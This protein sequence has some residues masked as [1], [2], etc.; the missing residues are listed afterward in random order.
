MQASSQRLLYD[1]SVAIRAGV[2]VV[3]GAGRPC[4]GMGVEASVHY[5][6]AATQH[7]CVGDGD[8]SDD[9]ESACDTSSEVGFPSAVDMQRNDND[10]T[11][12]SIKH[13]YEEHECG[14]EDSDVFDGKL[15]VGDGC[16]VDGNNFHEGNEHG[17]EQSEA[18]DDSLVAGDGFQDVGT[19][20]YEENDCGGENSDILDGK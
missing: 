1:I 5:S 18:S 2:E 11:E 17:G 12:R 7:F 19:N 10:I 6:G 14:C 15:L 9:E 8:K 4:E 3:A 20:D 16:E 13:G